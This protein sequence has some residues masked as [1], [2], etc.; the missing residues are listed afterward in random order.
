M[1]CT[2]VYAGRSQH[3]WA[4]LYSSLHFL[5]LSTTGTACN[6]FILVGK[7]YRCRRRWVRTAMS[8]KRGR[9]TGVAGKIVGRCTRGRAKGRASEEIDQQ[10]L[11]S[12]AGVWA[13][14]WP[15]CQTCCIWG[16]P[17]RSGMRGRGVQ[18]HAEPCAGARRRP[19][20][21]RRGLPGRA[22]RQAGR[23]SPKEGGF[24]PPR[25]WATQPR[26]LARTLQGARGPL[27][28][29]RGGTGW[30]RWARRT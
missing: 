24:L 26:A 7:R 21:P 8:A 15:A 28:P 16:N 29:R 25:A 22:T 4:L 27:T 13:M 19:G 11:V 3:L 23:G 30:S 5:S 18:R 20:T 10:V 14:K 12:E 9:A 2:L 17:D 6:S 1:R